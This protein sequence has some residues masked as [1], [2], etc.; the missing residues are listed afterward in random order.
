MDL[1]IQSSQKNNE[2]ANIK[3]AILHL[4]WQSLREMKIITLVIGG[5]V[6]FFL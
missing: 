5:A 2:I 6:I 1:L 4:S 3:I